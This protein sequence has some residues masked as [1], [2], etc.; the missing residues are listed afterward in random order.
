MLVRYLNAVRSIW[1]GLPTLYLE[2]TEKEFA[3]PC[4]YDDVEVK[5][6]LIGP[7]EMNA[8][9]ALT[10]P[11]D[12]RYEQVVLHRQRFGKVLHRAAEAL[13]VLGISGEDHT[14]AV[15]GVAKAIDAYLLEYGMT[16]SA[17]EAQQK[18]YTQS[19]E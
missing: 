16:R 3:N 7:L 14:D 8:G 9:F 5:E 19:R 4:S 11:A 10:D 12:P 6:L 17:Y 2:T 15:M 18:S 13:R 1:I